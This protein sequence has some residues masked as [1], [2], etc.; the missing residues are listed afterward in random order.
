MAQAVA[1]PRFGLQRFP[2][3]TVA[4]FAVT[5]VISILGLLMPWVLEALERTAQGLHGDWWRAFTAL[6]VQDGGVVVGT[7][8]NLGFLLV[9]GALAEQLVGRG[10]WLVCYFGAGLAGVLV[11]ALVV[12]ARGAAAG[13]HGGAVVVWGAAVAALGGGPAGGGPRRGDGGPAPAGPRRAR[14]PGGGQRGHH[15]R[16]GPR[17]CPG[18]PR[19][20]PAGRGP[21]RDPA[22]R[23]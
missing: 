21:A 23:R 16:P 11:V 15:V 14:R 6:F 22:R 2:A 7:V 9:M 8:S 18:H 3:V 12:G 13:A 17:R 19:R 4:V 5:A 1:R 10:Q 20:G